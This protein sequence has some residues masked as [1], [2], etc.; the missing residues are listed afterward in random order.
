MTAPRLPG[1]RSPSD[2][3]RGAPFEAGRVGGRVV[4]VDVDGCAVAD[5]YAHIRV[6]GAVGTLTVGDLVVFEGDF[7]GASFRAAERTF[8]ALGPLPPGSGEQSRFLYGGVGRRLRLRSIAL[9]AIRR[10]FEEEGF[11]EVDTPALAECPGLDANVFSLGAADLE[12]HTLHL[13][14]S[15][16]FHMKRL[17]VGGLPRIYQF[18]HSHRLGESGAFHEPI[19]SLLEWYRAFADY[20]TMLTDTEHL[21]R[22][23]AEECLET[24]SVRVSVAGS[25]RTLPLDEPFERLT[26][27]DAFTRFAGVPDPGA[28]FRRSPD[29]Y[30]QTH[31]DRVEPRL[32]ALPRPVF[33][34][35]FPIELAALARP[36]PTNPAVAERFELYVGGVE[37]SNGYGELTDPVAQRTRF[38]AELAGRFARGEP[39]YPLDE[40]FLAALEEG[41][42]P[43]SGNA[44]GLDRWVALLAGDPEIQRGIAFPESLRRAAKSDA[45]S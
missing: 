23:S 38:E 42:P 32:A 15:P 30:F 14:T 6:T 33:L 7:D 12:G 16:E 34:V 26:V 3:L 11:V 8:R 37:L 44:L 27:R 10:Y 35:D 2:V 4:A 43:S 21:L 18:A 40:R 13:V 20:E 9:R 41:L 22:R 1:T 17:L 31:V 19:F 45:Q 24:P 36:S 29:D 28:L 39:V 25:E 5:A